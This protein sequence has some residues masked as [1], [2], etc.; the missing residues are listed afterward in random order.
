[1]K[2]IAILL[3]LAVLPLQPTWAGVAHCPRGEH[4]DASLGEH[5][6]AV[7]A[8]DAH[9]QGD[10]SHRADGHPHGDAHGHGSHGHDGA[11]GGDCSPFQFVAMTPLVLA[12]QWLPLAGA[13]IAGIALAG[14][15]SHIPDGLDRPNWRCAV[16]FDG[17]SLRLSTPHP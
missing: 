8:Q 13:T 12:P 10:G 6:A 5:D 2:R 11:A 1:V 9:R 17:T 16:G 3:L 7:D 4:Y 14:Y 15:K